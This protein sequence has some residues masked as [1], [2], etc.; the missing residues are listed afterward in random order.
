LE[1]VL[2]KALP[3]RLK[4][5]LRKNLAKK[6]NSKLFSWIKIKRAGVA[7]IFFTKVYEKQS[8]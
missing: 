1:I 7:E 6:I 4:I 3:Y 2:K 8:Y 5:D